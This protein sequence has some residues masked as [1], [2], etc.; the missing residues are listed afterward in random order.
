MASFELARKHRLGQNQMVL[1]VNILCQEGGSKQFDKAVH[2]GLGLG[3]VGR[4][5]IFDRLV[6]LEGTMEYGTSFGSQ[7]LSIWGKSWRR[8]VKYPTIRF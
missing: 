2:V 1:L 7:V 5:K 8:L 3:V 4:H 6:I